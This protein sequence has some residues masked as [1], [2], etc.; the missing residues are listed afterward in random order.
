MARDPKLDSLRVEPTGKCWWCGARADSQEHRFK[1][2]SLRRVADGKGPQNVF[3]KSDDYSDVLKSLSKGSQVRWPKNLCANCNNVRSQPFDYA[4]DRF[5]EFLFAHGRE[6]RDWERLDWSTIYGQ[7]WQQSS[8]DL[9]RYFGKQIGCMLTAQDLPVPGE[10]IAFLD[11]AERC[12]S[13]CFML[14]RNW[15]GVAADRTMRRHGAVDDGL[16]SFIGLL[17]STAYTTEGIFSGVDYGYHIGY[18]WILAQ[19]R[20]GTDRSSWFEHP[21]IDVPL[22]NGSL[23]DQLGWLP[24]QLHMEYRHLSS[25]FRT[26][27]GKDRKARPES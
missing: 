12:P 18:V 1:H 11:G 26:F 6:M 23:R 5:E 19:W 24:H 10:L 27:V 4:Y 9:A 21:S 20:A 7:E 8:T 13:V 14:F 2:S 25:V 15:R 17:P 16:M 3:K 22:V